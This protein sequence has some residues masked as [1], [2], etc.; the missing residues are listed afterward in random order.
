MSEPKSLVLVVDDYATNRLKLTTAV[1]N[2]G[3][4]VEDADGGQAALDRVRKGGIDLVL[5]DIVMP[6]IDGFAVLAAMKS[7][8][9]LKEIP[10]LVVSSLEDLLEAVTAIEMGAEDFLTKPFDPVLLR[11]RVNTCLERK[12]L[13]DREIDYLNDVDR[14]SAAARLLE[15]KGIDPTKLGLEGVADRQEPLGDLARVFLGMADQ[16]FRRELFYRRQINLLRG[17][18]LLILFGACFGLVPA[19]SRFL[20]LDGFNPVGLAAWVLTLSSGFA[21]IGC[22]LTG[23]WPRI[24]RRALPYLIMLALFGTVFPEI[25]L[26]WVA[27]HVPAMVLSLIVTLEAMIVFAIASVLGL[28]APSFR[29]FVGL[30]LGLVCVLL[31][32]VPTEASGVGANPMWLLAA[33]LVPLL[34]AAE[35]LLIAS[36]KDSMDPMALIMAITVFGA[37]ITMPLAFATGN[38]LPPEAL[39]STTWAGIAAIAAA[40]VLGTFVLI[41]TIRSNGAVF[42]SQG[43][44]TIALAGIVW[45]MLLLDERISIW[46]AAA[47]ACM[48]SGVVLVRPQD[49]VEADGAG[50]A[51]LVALLEKGV[52]VPT[53]AAPPGK[54]AAR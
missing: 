19:V 29:R 21:L 33:L 25:A 38:F 27:E 53:A 30:C 12:R 6:D 28:E 45:S 31:I 24:E 9:A 41:C 50:D 14:L 32:I 2:L 13:R 34:Y 7:D 16:I 5:L 44:Y 49:E 8:P 17:S 4:A 35:D 37:L 10:V 3:H 48:I 54:H 36:P 23:S 18:I 20:T 11:A 39:A 22:I 15:N 42:A 51:E 52:T 26:L 47:V 40:S 46:I 43:A 1:R